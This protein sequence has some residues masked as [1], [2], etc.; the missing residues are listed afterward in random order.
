MKLSDNT[1]SV[2]KNFATINSGVV[3][4][5]GKVQK[6]IS[7]EKSI[8]VEATL[9]DDIPDRFG[10]YDLNQFL[11]NI[12]TL[13]NPDVTFSK[14]SVS[15]TE[16]DFTL[17]YLACS[18]NLIITPP[19]KEL[20]LKTVDVAFTLTSASL[21]R[22]LKLAQMNNLPNLSVVGK[23]GELLLKI[24]EKANDTSNYGSGKIGDYA[25]ADFSATFK[26][27]NLKLLTDDYDVELQIGA[28]AKFVNK[29][30]NLKYFIALETK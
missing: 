13:K 30:G 16:G 14:D 18:P 25:G 5:S 11:G 9:E 27:E 2:L 23:D 8:L 1:L 7:P 15:L 10:I 6:T 3:L 21:S 22:L 29:A 26:T 4:Q 17:T 19:E 24:H 12:T 20:A 28:F